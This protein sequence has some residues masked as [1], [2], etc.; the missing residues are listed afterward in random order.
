MD[1]NEKNKFKFSAGDRVFVKIKGYP[2]WPAFINDINTTN[3]LPKYNVTFYGTKETSCVKEIDMCLYSENKSRF[4]NPKTK[5]KKFES[6]IKEIEL[7]FKKQNSLSV[8]KNISL[9]GFSQNSVCDS[10][11]F[12]ESPPV[13]SSPISQDTEVYLIDEPIVQNNPVSVE[14]GLNIPL[15]L[16]ES[17]WVTDDTVRIVF[18]VLNQIMADRVLFLDPVV[19]VAIK[20]LID[21]KDVIPTNEI[22][23]KHYIFIPVN[24]SSSVQNIGGSGTHW[25]LL[26]WDKIREVFYHFDSLGSVNLQYA[27]TIAERLITSGKLTLI[28]VMT[29]L[30]KNGYDCGIHM[31]LNATNILSKIMDEHLSPTINIFEGPLP[32]F[33]ECELL[34]ARAQFALLMHNKQYINMNK[35]TLKDLIFYNNFEKANKLKRNKIRGS[36]SYLDKTLD[37][38][39]TRHKDKEIL[40]DTSTNTEWTVQLNKRRKHIVKQSSFS[41]EM[42]PLQ[43]RYTCISDS[44]DMSDPELDT[45]SQLRSNLSTNIELKKKS[46]NNK[47]ISAHSEV[48][49]AVSSVICKKDPSR[50]QRI[51]GK[52]INK[53]NVHV[54]A[55]SHGKKLYASLKS[56]LPDNCD[57]IVHSSPGAPVKHI[58]K[59]IESGINLLH[60]NDVIVVIAGSNDVDDMIQNNVNPCLKISHAFLELVEKY[61]EIKFVIVPLPHRFDLNTN[62][63]INNVINKINNALNSNKISILNVVDLSSL[64]RSHFTSHGQHLNKA[65]KSTLA[66]EITEVMYKK[67]LVTYE[68]CSADT[69]IDFVEDHMGNIMDKHLKNKNVCF[70]H[71]ISSDI[72]HEK[73]MSAGVASIFKHK[74][75]KPSCTD[76]LNESLT[77]QEINGGPI[78][79]GLV[80]KKEYYL[81]PS[82]ESY[83]RAFSALVEDF[84]KKNLKHL[85]CSPMGCLRDKVS[86]RHFAKNIVNFQHLTGASITIVNY[87]DKRITRNRFSFSFYVF[88]KK[89]RSDILN[90]YLA[91]T[92]QLSAT[93]LD[94]RE[95]STRLLVQDNNV[96]KPAS[97]IDFPPLIVKSPD[98]IILNVFKTPTSKDLNTDS[99]ALNN[100]LINPVLLDS[101]FL[102]K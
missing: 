2:Y 22:K 100:V 21:F 30:Q 95:S 35:D 37:G 60:K 48:K 79:Y 56:N 98:S 16:L 3:K 47:N 23:G 77:C 32:D 62:H 101:S 74:F 49:H 18:D 68:D 11:N 82:I 34:T 93:H 71:C 96:L 91:R 69:N 89:V 39:P 12:V 81:K 9:N 63:R 80:T 87:N 45:I 5:S 58:I 52:L 8:S 94:I 102:D 43:N 72:T 76:F 97:L 40:V 73:N 33:K 42:I 99:S 14:E 90:E 53:I 55:D 20:A 88:L 17:Q 10:I 29:P 28:N 50:S 6:A 7:S 54:Y 70:A 1:I 59:N 75:G 4:A 84:K 85:F 78:I 36:Y 19:T 24:N 83:D 67:K 92:T 25:S 38:N 27:E 57:V 41:N 26:L 13:A 61:K 65:G 51:N 66:N 31:I 15:T 64:K 86:T 44:D 46:L